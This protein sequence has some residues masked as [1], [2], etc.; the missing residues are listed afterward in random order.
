[1]TRLA[2]LSFAAM[3]SG[4]AAASPILAD[5]AVVDPR[6]Y[7]VETVA[8]GMNFP[9]S[10]AFL[11]DGDF[12]VTERNGGVRLI[13]DGRL[14]EQPLDGA[15]AAFQSGQGG[16]HDIA[17][18]PD[19]ASNQRVFIAF[20]EGAAD[21]NHTAL[22]RA[23]F[24]GTALRDVEIIFRNRP[25]KDTANHFGGK[26]AFLPDGTLLLSTGDGFTY[27]E[28]A[29]DTSSGLGK[30][31]RLTT[32]G[33]PAP[34]NPFAGD[35]AAMAEIWSYGHRN[36][37]GLAVDPKT[38]TVYET[39]HG[40]LSGD[41][42]NRIEKGANY[43]WPV[44]TYSV[45]YSGSVISPHT[46]KEGAR[47]PL[48]VWKPERFAPSGLVVYRGTLFP[49]W[50]GSLLAGGLAGHSVRRLTLDASGDVTGQE[51]LF[52]ELGERIRDVREG[53]DGALYLLTDGPQ[54]KLLRV[55]PAS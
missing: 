50:D 12:L 54:G 48:A 26:I 8:E 11:P 9:W 24:D 30:I 52:S 23:R 25:D 1:M 47:P 7:K 35:A 20:A 40:A 29:Q 39:E 27:R 15:P 2:T 55:T 53:P 31:L 38:G 49:G 51:S 18:D 22:A 4:A 17:L 10:V 21:A 36:V 5:P 44:A 34:D 13:R 6:S 33:A 3:L 16:L 45:D 41:E 28:K 43:G 19:F 14:V 46:E 42:V 37:Q 32:D